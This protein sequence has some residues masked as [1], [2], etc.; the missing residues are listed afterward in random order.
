MSAADL[1]NWLQSKAYLTEN[2]RPVSSSAGKGI[3]VENSLTPAQEKT[4]LATAHRPP[5]QSIVLK[6][7]SRSFVGASPIADTHLALKFYYR[8]SLR[9]QLGYTLRGSRAMRSWLASRT[10]THLGIPTPAP[11]AL[12][13]SKRF[14][15]LAD[16]AL[17]VTEI[18]QG[19]PLPEFLEQHNKDIPA[20]EKIAASAR[21]IFQTFAHHRIHHGD[22]N[23]KNFIVLP[24]RSLTI[25]DL[26]AVELLVPDSKWKKKR[27]SD[28]RQ[29]ARLW[30]TYPHLKQTFSKTFEQ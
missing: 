7:G 18:A 3:I 28:E 21:R 16:R 2:T 20:M 29:F 30:Q 24:D 25:I 11:I 14:G 9:R 26:D 10:F 13:E 15:F 1:E 19:T 27:A 6:Y 5:A 4:L 22:T 23:T 12:I 17:F 8:L